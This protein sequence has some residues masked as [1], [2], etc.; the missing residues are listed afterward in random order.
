MNGPAITS[1]ELRRWPRRR[2]NARSRRPPTGDPF[3]RT[4]RD[5]PTRALTGGR[6]WT[7][8][9]RCAGPAADW[10]SASSTASCTTPTNAV[11]RRAKPRWAAWDSIGVPAAWRCPT[12]VP[13]IAPGGVTNASSR[14]T[15]M[16][17]PTGR[18]TPTAGPTQRPARNE[19]SPGPSEGTRPRTPA[20]TRPRAA[21]GTRPRSQATVR[22]RPSSSE[23]FGS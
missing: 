7:A 12:G 4:R 17:P 5:H 11:T 15:A 23:T 20:A 13:K 18:V 9:T 22:P 2:R 10:P 3:S 19:R 8:P 14:T 6:S 21:A 16:T 1:A